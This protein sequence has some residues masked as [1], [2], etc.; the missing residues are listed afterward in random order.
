[1]NRVFWLFCLWLTGAPV[2]AIDLPMESRVPGG[3]ALVELGVPASEAAPEARY[4]NRRVLLVPRQDQWI[5]V[6][7]IPLTAALGEHNL[8]IAGK[9]TGKIAFQV[10]DK[11]YTTQHLT[12]KNQQ[13]VT[14]D[15][16][17]LARINR[18]T[19]VINDALQT[20]NGQPP[21]SL[22]LDLPVQGPLSSP[23]GLKR[24][25]NQQPRKPHSGVDIAAAPGTPI[26]APAEGVVI[27][28]GE[29]FFNG[30]TVFIDHGQGLITMYCHM[31]RIDVTPGR[32]LKRGELIGTV[33][34]S[35][36][37]TGPH[38][39]WGVSLNNAFID[40]FLVTPALRA[41]ASRQ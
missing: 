38:L 12:V 29:Y 16:K 9:K 8:I 23:F 32:R 27:T 24:F 10:Q 2:H 40:P 11:Q 25:F 28:T 7:G 6:V 1:M 19:K 3:L 34:N 13:H 21:A 36:R 15:E 18:E 33:G 14:P 37:A 22:L 30:N 20:W 31:Q 5:A 17:N 26:T 41:L 35:G 4:D 39:H